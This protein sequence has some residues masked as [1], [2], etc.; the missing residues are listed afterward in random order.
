MSHCYFGTCQNGGVRCNRGRMCICMEGTEG[1]CCR[2]I[3]A[4]QKDDFCGSDQT[5]IC[6]YDRNLMKAVCHC[7]SSNRVFDNR[8]K[9]CRKICYEDDDCANG[10]MCI[11]EF[12]KKFCICMP[13]T[14]GDFCSE[15]TDCKKKDF[16]GTS[17][18]TS[19]MYDIT[20]MQAVCN[21]SDSSKQF[22]YVEQICKTR[23]EDDSNCE[24]GHKCIRDGASKYCQCIPGKDINICSH[25]MDCDEPDS[26]G[27]DNNVTCEYD[28]TQM[29]G[30]CQCS[31]ASKQFDYREK[32][33]K[34]P[35]QDSDCENGGKCTGHGDFKFCECLPGT[36]GDACSDVTDCNETDFCGT[37]NDTTCIYNSIRMEATCQCLNSSKQFDYREK[38]CRETCREGDCENG[39]NCTLSDD[40]TFCECLPGTSG[41]FCSE[42]IECEEGNL[43]DTHNDSICIYDSYRR[44]AICLCFK[45]NEEFNYEEKICKNP[46]QENDCENGG[47]CTGYGDLKFC[48][49]LPGT[50]GDH[51]SEIT[52][53]KEDNL[54]GTDSDAKCTYD[55]FRMG[56]FCQCSNL[57]KQFDYKDK[58]CKEPCLSR[59]CHNYGI[60]T[61]HGDNKFCECMPGTTGDL[62]SE[63]TKCKED[64]FC[65]KDMTC[66]YDIMRRG[67][68]CRCLDWKKHFDTKQKM[69][70]SPCEAEMCENGG[71]C[72]GTHDLKFCECLPGTTGDFCTEISVC[73]GKFICGYDSDVRCVYDPIMQRAACECLN[74]NANF[75]YH[76]QTCECD[77]GYN[78]T[79]GLD[80]LGKKKCF[81][82]EGFAEFSGWC[83]ECSCGSGENCSFNSYGRKMCTCN[84]GF[85]DLNGNCE[86][87]L[88]GESKESTFPAL[89]GSLFAFLII[90]FSGLIYLRW[91]KKKPG[92]AFHFK[93]LM[94]SVDEEYERSVRFK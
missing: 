69:C 89:I 48:E 64:N 75:N 79:C 35:C 61:S 7:S 92:T 6:A 24:N 90:V 30:R 66:F 13:G 42:V 54:C 58:T 49:C 85:K 45:Q 8:Q 29:K 94:E 83:E 59:G 43:C 27:I 16:C 46:C 72:N 56:A 34:E 67:G 31:N 60:C 17:N 5:A 22:D 73:R 15:I 51:C 47:N 68:S 2:D 23:C 76:T 81:C 57:S 3:V 77:C 74:P 93:T 18:E 52:E 50:K 91:R 10:G 65:R 84:I 40:F 55:S 78:G 4:C 82:N 12:G 86:R 28:A 32:I 14:E 87:I 63:V 19:C 26:C 1:Y 25:V 38:V 80:V 36:T 20:Q 44:E 88:L 71:I 41:D 9:L 33:C 37:G 62:C 11:G 53:C 39:A 70:R 21:C